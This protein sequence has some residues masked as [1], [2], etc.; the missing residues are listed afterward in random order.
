MPPEERHKPKGAHRTLVGWA[1]RHCHCHQVGERGWPLSSGEFTHRFLLHQFQG[2]IYLFLLTDF[3]ALLDVFQ[4]S[5]FSLKV[6]VHTRYLSETR[7]HGELSP[8]GRPPARPPVAFTRFCSNGCCSATM[9]STHHLPQSPDDTN[10]LLN[11]S[12]RIMTESNSSSRPVVL[13]LPIAAAL[14]S[15]SSRCGDPPT[16][17]LFSL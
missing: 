17:W 14:Q 1:P 8:E 6:V 4:V 10:H 2:H 13:S 3:F 5:D 9:I 11:H 12:G 7:A 16:I 15:S